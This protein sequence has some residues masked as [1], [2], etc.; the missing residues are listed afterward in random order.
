MTDRVTAQQAR[1]GMGLFLASESVFFLM[2]I[3]AFVIFRDVSV[4]E[5]A[6][7]LNFPF[8]AVYTAC[9]LGS[10]L[11]VRQAS[12]VAERT[13]GGSPRFWLGATALLGSVFLFGQGSEY[14][15][16]SHRGVSMS[17]S[18]FGTTLF[19][20]TGIHGLHILIGIVLLATMIWI[21]R[22]G[23]AVQ[24]VAAFWLFICAVWMV[25]FSV[26]YIWTFL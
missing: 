5:A 9:V 10:G 24:T 17:Q 12:R 19:T 16:L 8:A 15:R 20:L 1:L 14:L 22:G 2:L 25:I 4:K 3:V 11:T 7:T 21:P 13:G 18:L 6:S 26:V 23:Q